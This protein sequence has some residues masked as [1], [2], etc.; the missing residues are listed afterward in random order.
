MTSYTEEKQQQLLMFVNRVLNPEPVVKAGV[1]TGS[2]VT[3]LARTEPD[4][5]AFVF[6]DLLDR[7]IIMIG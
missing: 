5:D 7:K 6:F 1:S 4:I 2:I 3:G